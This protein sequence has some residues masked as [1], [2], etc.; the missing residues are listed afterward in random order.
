VQGAKPDFLNL[1]AAILIKLKKW[2]LAK[3]LV[4]QV[5]DKQPTHFSARFNLST[6]YAEEQNH[7]EANAILSELSQQHDN[8]VQV[9]IMLARMQTQLSNTENAVF[10]LQKALTLQTDNVQALELLSDIYQ[11]KNQLVKAVRQLNNLTYLAPKNIVYHFQKAELY[12]KQQ[13]D[14]SL[15]G[16]LR[17]LGS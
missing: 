6:I 1:K 12:L 17:E 9:L 2:D 13:N 14:V 16:E 8:N 4:K 7:Q 11:Q 5:L 3:P 15:K 10:N